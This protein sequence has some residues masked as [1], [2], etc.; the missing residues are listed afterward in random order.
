MAWDDMFHIHRQPKP[1]PKLDELR[2]IERT[3][4]RIEADLDKLVGALVPR[5][6]FIKIAFQP[7]RGLQGDVMAEGPVVLASGQLTT[8]SI[9]YFDQTGAPM[10]ATF[11]PPN[12]TFAID[13][14]AIATSTPNPDNQ[15]DV[16]AYVSAGV[17]NLTASCTSAEGLALTDTE[18]VTCSPVVLPPPV[19]SSIKV[20]FAAPTGGT[21]VAAARK[22]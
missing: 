2:E 22:K 19:L 3:D 17:A 16:V 7:P 4:Q 15:T 8:A 1:D 6:S 5:L 9:D 11:V 12:I 13:N 18:T 10:P 20:N 21:A 14:P